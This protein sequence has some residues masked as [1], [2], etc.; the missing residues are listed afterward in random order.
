MGNKNS[1]SSGGG[2]GGAN[3]LSGGNTLSHTSSS[4]R[5]TDHMIRERH[6][7]VFKYYQDVRRLGEGSIG[8]VRLV[9]R[10]KGTEGGSAYDNSTRNGANRGG[11][12]ACLID[13]IFGCSWLTPRSNNATTATIGN[14]HSRSNQSE[15][16][17]S[18]HSELYALK[19]I[20]LR[21]VQKEYLDE[22]RN[23]ISVLRSLDHPN[24]VK[25]Y[26]V[27]ETKQNIYVVMEYCSGGD[28]YSR[29]PYV[30]SQ[31]ANIIS[32][33]CS[34]IGHMHDNGII[35]R[36]IKMENIMF[37]S[38][39]P[40]AK[41]KL[42]D[43]GLSKKYLPGMYMSDWCGTVYTMSPQVIDGVYTN[44]AD[45]WSIGVIAFLLLCNEKPF[46]GKRSEM[47]SK[48]KYCDYTFKSPGW[49]NVSKDAKRFVAALLTKDPTKR[50]SA[51]EALQ[52]SWLNKKDFETV[53]T[54]QLNERLMANVKDNI[55]SFAQTSELKRIAAVIVAHKSSVKEILDMRRAFEK[56]D[57]EKDGVIT[58]DEFKAAMAECDEYSDEDVN[59][60]FEQMDVNK[61]G[62]IMYT[63]FVAATLE[64]HGR[65][66]EK[67]L[68]EAF[69]HMD[70]DDSG[71]ISKENLKKLLGESGTP[72]R[73]EKL[74]GSADSDGD[75]RIS[76][77]E[78]LVMFRKDN[79]AAVDDEII[80]DHVDRRK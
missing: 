48:I 61:N 43:F 77:E 70:D 76:F 9:K 26:E 63:E 34:A 36:D 80:T 24:I 50:L 73:L 10:K 42:L 19:S 57:K 31:A 11:A 6:A 2:S 67:R 54:E 7:N 47:L 62:K 75:G 45:C 46:R 66:E 5:L 55:L 56:F 44:K 69:D 28:L 20:Q 64:L 33:L 79:I 3:N 13:G 51:E 60:I 58:I 41:I 29:V 30:E 74:I 23:E 18:D 38:S 53:S 16:A 49:S 15:S 1:S 25:A 39:D 21:L 17:I 65:V 12:C 27:Y 78:F 14:Y 37:E 72:E 68:A 32:Q 59:A 52:H 40:T 8:T 71:F 35:H 4:N 22:L